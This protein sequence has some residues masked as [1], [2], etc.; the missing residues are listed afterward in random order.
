MNLNFDV[1]IPGCI[2]SVSNIVE[3]ISD[4]IGKLHFDRNLDR[5]DVIRSILYQLRLNFQKHNAVI[6][7]K[8]IS[9][10]NLNE[11]ILK[12]DFKIQDLK[13]FF[14]FEVIVFK[15]GNITIFHS[16]G[17]GKKWGINNKVFVFFSILKFII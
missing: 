7:E 14:E 1:N 4:Y 17:D 11:I 2:D 8:D 6:V 13:G 3:K 16:Y 12:K 9:W 5:Q 10:P 15:E